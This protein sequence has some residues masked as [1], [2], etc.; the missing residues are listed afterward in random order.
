M[1]I[2]CIFCERTHDKRATHFARSRSCTQCGHPEHDAWRCA[3]PSFLVED[4]DTCD[5]PFGAQR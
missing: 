3:A 2:D 4:I 5:C 1:T